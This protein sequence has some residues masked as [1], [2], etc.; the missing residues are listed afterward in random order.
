[1]T[2]A[3]PPAGA[4]GRNSG[5]VFSSLIVFGLLMPLT[6]CGEDAAT[7]RLRVQERILKRE[8]ESLRDL[9]RATSDGNLVAPTWIAVAVDEAAVR[10]LV[11]AGLP[12]EMVVA[13]RLRVRVEKAE[14]S[15]SSG[16]S[17]V[18][19]RAQV[20]DVR[21]PDR[22]ASV[23]YTG[24]LDEIA[25]TADGKLRTRVL[26]DSVEVS[27]AQGR[28]SDASLLE[29]AAE[30]LAGQGLEELQDLIPPVAIPVKL[31][32][33]LVF[34]GIGEGPIQVD[35]GE[36]PVAVRVA[37]VMPLSG[38]LWVFLD[39]K[40]GAWRKTDTVSPSLA[41]PAAGATP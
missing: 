1:V 17:L 21:S 39:L 32:Q 37:R 31:E 9:K 41:P 8:I 13:N 30:R 36:L 22:S 11:E 20:T 24:G 16:S 10:A 5:G 18:S 15:F 14:V 4:S 23:S 27:R 12:Q 38:R 40:T 25:V 19:L 3:V 7:R 26:I 35:P 33:G 6:G 29:A 34:G 2:T 28:G